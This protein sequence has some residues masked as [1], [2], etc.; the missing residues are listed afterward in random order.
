M[1]PTSILIAGLFLVASGAALAWTQHTNIS[2]PLT[3]SE[4]SDA[5]QWLSEMRKAQE[6]RPVHVTKASDGTVIE[7]YADGSAQ[8]KGPNG[9]VCVSSFAHGLTA[10]RKGGVT[11]ICLHQPDN[12]YHC[13]TL[14][15]EQ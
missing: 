5:E 11:K 7:R 12:S 8:I 4:R 3:D 15:A 6:Q 1:R 13:D 10:C 9:G 2:G 14:E